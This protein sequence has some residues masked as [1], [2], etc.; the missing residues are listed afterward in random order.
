M[1]SHTRAP[2]LAWYF[3]FISPYAYLQLA[4]HPDL[5][6]R[7]GLVFKPILFAGLLS[8]WGHKGPVEIPEKRRQTY[9]MIAY[10]AEQRGVTVNFPPG[11]PFNPVPALRL[12]IALAE[13]RPA[14]G[15]V[16]TI[17]EFIWKEGRS[18]GEE[19]SHLCKRLVADGDVLIGAQSV[20]DALRANG[21]EAIRLGI[22]GV[23]TFV[24][25]DKDKRPEL[26][27]GED[28]TGLL[29]R[30]LADPGY[31]ASPA[32]QRLETLPVAA[33]RKTA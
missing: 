19:W 22:Y 17:F 32:M 6:E 26:F 2:T 24:A 18:I 29:R 23:P 10:S 3:D 4:A 11:H 30:H 21:E 27:W 15:V 5:F 12:A 16:R 14:L 1:S 25:S 33:A 28:A 8:H 31:L 20:K 13:T 7:P 9:R